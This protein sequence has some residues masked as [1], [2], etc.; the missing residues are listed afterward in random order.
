MRYYGNVP[1]E[2]GS[3]K[4]YWT[5]TTLRVYLCDACRKNK[6]AFEDHAEWV[7]ARRNNLKEWNNGNR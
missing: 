3:H 1:C 7:N 4:A 5:G 6:K 2:C